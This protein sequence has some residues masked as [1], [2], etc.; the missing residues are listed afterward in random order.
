M[1]SL[2]LALVALGLT[3]PLV[4]VL[5][6]ANELFMLRVRDG[7]VT[8]GR[9]R[10]PQLL[11]NDVVDVLRGPPLVREG[12]LRGVSEGGRVELYAEAELTDAQRQRLRNVLAQWPV[13]RVRNANKPR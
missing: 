8:I 5:L 10:I 4:V 6:R 2:L 1:S 13:T 9:G 11:L 3:A 7:A 12:T